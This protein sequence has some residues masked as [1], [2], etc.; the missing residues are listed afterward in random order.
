M[1]LVSTVIFLTPLLDPESPVRGFATS[2]IRA[3]AK[4]FERVIVVAGSAH[5]DPE[6]LGVDIVAASKGAVPGRAPLRIERTLA[7]AV[8][9]VEGRVVV[10]VDDDLPCLVQAR[11]A[12]TAHRVPVLWWCPQVPSTKA[13]TTAARFAD[14][15]LV[16]SEPDVNLPG[17]ALWTVGAG[18]DVAAFAPSANLPSRPPLRLLTLGRTSRRK[19]FSV[20]LRAV[21]IARSQGSDTRL[22]IFGPSTTAAESLH[23]TELDDLVKNT[24]LTRVV[25]IHDAVAPRRV[26]EIL[27]QA[28]VLIDAGPDDDVSLSVLEAMAAGR[29]VLSASAR[30]APM[31]EVSH[32]PLHFDAG[33]PSGLAERIVALSETWGADLSRIGNALR[34]VV[35]R[36][37]SLEHWQDRVAAAVDEVRY[38]PAANHDPVTD[39]PPAPGSAPETDAAEA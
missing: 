21:A 7:G 39:A 8:S 31:L 27:H 2:H 12:T 35:A 11:S 28:H 26:P 23:R 36:E 34:H 14:G 15:L 29:V 3:L 1:R 22:A 38:R 16:A 6:R 33:D 17:C 20:I 13:A 37:N 25:E 10:M 9:G 32:I 18:I 30:V 24:A 5:C 19:G 4:R